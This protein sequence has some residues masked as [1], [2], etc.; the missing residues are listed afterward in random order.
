[1]TFIELLVSSVILLTAIT[2]GLY[3]LQLGDYLNIRAKID[4]RIA[5]LLQREQKKLL[6][7]I[8][9]PAIGTPQILPDEPLYGV[10]VIGGAAVNN[11]TATITRR[12]TDTGTNPFRQ[13]YE[14]EIK[15]QVPQKN[16]PNLPD[17]AKNTITIENIVVYTP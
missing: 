9:N 16:K 12:R 5:Y 3:S 6:N 7:N 1:M 13:T 4:Q 14:V 8:G 17:A 11:Y 15:Y 2:I 10:K